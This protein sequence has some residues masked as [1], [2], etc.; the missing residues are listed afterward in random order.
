MA[1]QSNFRVIG[2]AIPVRAGAL[3]RDRDHGRDR[4]RHPHRRPGG[5]EGGG[6]ARRSRHRLHLRGANPASYGLAGESGCRTGKVTEQAW[7]GCWRLRRARFRARA[8]GAAR[9]AGELCHRR[10]LG[11]GRSA[12][13]VGHR[14]ACDM[15]VLTVDGDA[16]GNLVHCIRRCDMELAGVASASYVGALV[17]GRGRTG[18]GR[19]LHRSGRRHDRRVDLHP[20][21][22]DLC[23]CGAMGGEL[24]TRTSPRACGQPMPWPSG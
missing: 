5:A 8:R 11:P 12:R 1:G 2:A 7:R 10:P 19:G 17:A 15:H 6:R 18:T 4:A 9:P 13:P 16:A 3:W 14:L 20:Q 21:A 23:R 22:H 24:I